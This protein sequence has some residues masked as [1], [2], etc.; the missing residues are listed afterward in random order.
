MMF[1]M[2]NKKLAQKVAGKILKKSDVNPE[3]SESIPENSIDESKLEVANEILG[4]I[5]SKDAKKFLSAFRALVLSCEGEELSEG[6]EYPEDN[7]GKELTKE[8]EIEIKK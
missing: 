1:M 7:Y 2:D 8:V 6:E 3:M 5:E 4:A